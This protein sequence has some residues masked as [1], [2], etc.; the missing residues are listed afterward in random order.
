MGAADSSPGVTPPGILFSYGVHDEKTGNSFAHQQTKDDSS[1]AG[2]YRVAL[3]DG[4]TQI[5]SYTADKNGYKAV[6]TY[7]GVAVHP[8]DPPKDSK[9]TEAASQRTTHPSGH[10]THPPGHATHPPGHA[11]HPSGHAAHPSGHVTDPSNHLDS[12]LE[13]PLLVKP[14]PQPV[15]PRPKAINFNSP[16]HTLQDKVL[17]QPLQSP[18]HS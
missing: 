4:R 18:V 10:A 2:E 1:T 15:H 12:V 16:F 9:N 11:T 8:D 6:V 3:P 17:H 7:E 13:H 14:R 5:V